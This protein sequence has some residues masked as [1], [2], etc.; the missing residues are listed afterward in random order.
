MPIDISLGQIPANKGFLASDE[1]LSNAWYFWLRNIG[2]I[3]KQ[4]AALNLVVGTAGIVIGPDAGRAAALAPDIVYFTTDTNTIYTANH[5]GT[6][7]ETMIPAMTGDVTNPAGSNV[8]TLATVNPSTGTFVNPTITVNGKGLITGISNG[9]STTSD[10]IAGTIQLADGSGGFTGDQDNWYYQFT[11]VP[12]IHLGDALLG[13][14]GPTF[15]LDSALAASNAGVPVPSTIQAA[16]ELNLVGTEGINLSTGGVSYI[17]I[18]ETGEIL[19]QGASGTAGQV[20]TS[21][22]PGVPSQWTSVVNSFVTTLSGLTPNVSSTG[23]IT[24]SGV[25]GIP[26]GGTGATTAN[27]AFN[28]LAPS[29]TGHAG[30]FLTTDGTNTSWKEVFPSSY[31]IPFSFGDVSPELIGL[32]PANK[33]IFTVEVIVMV[34]F[35][36]VGA[37]L[38]VGDASNN[39]SLQSVG[40]NDPTTVATYTSTP[41]FLYGSATNANLYITPGS[42]STQGSGYV[43]IRTQ[44]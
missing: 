22:G 9:A 5:T 2:E 34:P 12:T 25:L 6:A 28:N 4:L 23:D 21:E 18:T 40:Q 10:G 19:L 39:S 35:D 38:T 13:P 7:W 42:G 11:G 43:A 37:S 27:D 26:S 3:V 33:L 24:L 36:G 14:V 16:S 30:E 32:I 8:L 44:D 41:S 29:Q 31:V 20:L 17:T 1:N 15:F